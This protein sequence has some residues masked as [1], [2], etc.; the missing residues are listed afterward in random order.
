MQKNETRS[1]LSGRKVFDILLEEKDNYVGDT[2]EAYI[3]TQGVG[4][5]IKFFL[6]NVQSYN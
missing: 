1:N 5:W 3:I 6:S 4:S 2:I